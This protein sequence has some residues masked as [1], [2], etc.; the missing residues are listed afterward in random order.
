MSTKT[1]FAA[2]AALAILVLTPGLASAQ[3]LFN[4]NARPEYQIE[5]NVYLPNTKALSGAYGSV[6][7]HAR[8]QAPT[9]TAVQPARDW[10]LQGRF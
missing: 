3:A 1:K 8:V 5:Q 7:K 6:G 10:Q 4:A 9:P 2:A